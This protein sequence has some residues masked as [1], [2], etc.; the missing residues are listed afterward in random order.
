M[1]QRS[2][3]ARLETSPAVTARYLV[4]LNKEAAA[5]AEKIQQNLEDLGA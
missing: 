4:D 2:F 5:L 3:V 1:T